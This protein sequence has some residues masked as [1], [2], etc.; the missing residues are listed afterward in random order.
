[1]MGNFDDL[2]HYVALG[3]SLSN[4]VAI[5]I[6][7]FIINTISLLSHPSSHSRTSPTLLVCCLTK[8]N[9]NDI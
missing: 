2:T 3:F 8:K 7:V 6:F 9:R 4:G 1:M 5:T